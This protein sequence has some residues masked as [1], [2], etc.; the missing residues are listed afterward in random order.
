MSQTYQLGFTPF[1]SP[2]KAINLK[3]IPQSGFFFTNGARTVVGFRQKRYGLLL[4][5]PEGEDLV[6]SSHTDPR[7]L[8]R[9]YVKQLKNRPGSESS[10]MLFDESMRHDFDEIFKR[11]HSKAI[12]AEAAHAEAEW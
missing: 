4:V 10:W 3:R 7:L 5:T 11:N 12:S 9:E 6:W 2:L 8:E 1:A